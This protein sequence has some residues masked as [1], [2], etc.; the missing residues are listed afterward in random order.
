ML[1]AEAQ[2]LHGFLDG[3][4]VLRAFLS[5]VRIIKT[6]MRIAAKVAGHA[7][8]NADALCVAD[9]QISVRLRREA[10]T[11]SRRIIHTLHLLGI[12]SRMT[13]PLS[14][15]SCSLLDIFLDQRADE[16]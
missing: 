12:G 8:I 10:G 4:H 9:M 5:R 16:V 13:A 6:H 15:N 11:D 3:L 1:P 2:P 7:E 14:G